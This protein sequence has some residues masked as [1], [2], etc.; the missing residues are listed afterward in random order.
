MLWSY[1]WVARRAQE[2]VSRGKALLPRAPS[3]A[4]VFKHQRA[5]YRKDSRSQGNEGCNANSTRIN[6]GAN[7]LGPSLSPFSILLKKQ[8]WSWGSRF[9]RGHWRPPPLFFGYSIP[10][11]FGLQPIPHQP[12]YWCF[13]NKGTFLPANLSGAP[14]QYTNLQ[15]KSAENGKHGDSFLPGG[16]ILSLSFSSGPAHTLPANS[17]L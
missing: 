16:C 8:S 3:C 12:Q 14:P 10:W 11:S 6:L 15:L 17:D 4:K 13:Y 9:C 2:R 5:A 1:R 7:Q